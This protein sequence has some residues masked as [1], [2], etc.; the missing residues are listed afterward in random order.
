MVTVAL[1]VRLE[2]KP[3]KESEL[4]RF[5]SRRFAARSGGT[6]NRCMVRN[7]AWSINFRHLRRFSERVRSPSSPLGQGGGGTDG[8]GLRTPCEPTSN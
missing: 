1:L 3:G 7:S 5:L 2:A 6:G 4:E 8:E